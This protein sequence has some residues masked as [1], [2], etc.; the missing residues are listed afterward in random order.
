MS[1]NPKKKIILES[2][3]NQQGLEDFK[4]TAL[5]QLVIEKALS[6]PQANNCI[7]S[8]GYITQE[9]FVCLTCF[10]ESKKMAVI[11]LACS[12]RCHDESH[13]MISI[14][15]KR[16]IRCD[17]GNNNFYLNCNLKKN[18]EISYDNP[19]NK[20]SHNMQG[21]YCYC[22]EEEDEKK[23]MIQCFFCIL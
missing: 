7:Y 13:E 23:M 20:Y 4:Q 8:K 10:K 2:L 9:C 12:L 18:I 22:D 1:E 14:G 11:Y 16:H 15:F 3:E 5:Q 6:L 21:K 19:E 17:C